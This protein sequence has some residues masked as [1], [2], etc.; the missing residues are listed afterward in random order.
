MKK[1]NLIKKMT[2]LI[3]LGNFLLATII[4]PHSAQAQNA[5]DL[6]MPGTMISPGIRYTPAIMAGMTIHPKNPFLFDFIIDTG[7]DN[8]QGEAFKAESQ[9]LI[10]YFLATLA[11]P[12]DEMWV[13]LSPHEKDRIVADSLGATA[14]G[15]DM[16]AQDYMLK[17][18]T[19]SL[20]YP[21]EKLGH[22]FWK[23]I[24]EKSQAKFGL[25]EIPINT[26]N[27][28]WIVPE[29]V[30]VYAN[31]V[32]VFV[33]KSHLKV[34]LEEDYLNL[35]SNQERTTHG[36]GKTTLTALESM[37]AEAKEVIREIIIPA[38]EKEVNEGEIF[39][40]LRQIYH[41]MILATWYKKNLQESILGKV[42]INSNKIKGIDLEDKDIKKKIYNQYLA[43]FEKGVYD[44]IRK[45]YDPL[46]QEIVP[47]KYFSGGIK[48]VKDIKEK[49]QIDPSS[50]AGD[51]RETR[52]KHGIPLQ[53]VRAKT[54]LIH[55][56]GD[57][58]NAEKS[59]DKDNTMSAKRIEV[60]TQKNRTAEFIAKNL[61]K[62][63]FNNFSVEV[64]RNDT[65]LELK[66]ISKTDD[67]KKLD[68]FIK[69][70]I[71]MIKW[72]GF[73]LRLS[74]D[75][76][77]TKIGPN[78]EG[79][80]T[81]NTKIINFSTKDA[82]FS[83]HLGIHS[84]KN[85]IEEE[86]IKT[87]DAI[88]METGENTYKEWTLNSLMAHPQSQEMTFAALKHQ[89][90]LFFV[91]IPPD[92]KSN[93]FVEKLVT[94]YL[95]FTPIYFAITNP[96]PLTIA[97]S[98]LPHV[99][100]M[101]ALAGYYR[102]HKWNTILSPILAISGFY[103]ETSLRSALTAKKIVEDI[104]PRMKTT[105][106]GK[107]LIF[108]EYGSAHSDIKFYI[109]N[110][111]VRE[112]VI[113]LHR[114]FNFGF[115]DSN[116]INKIGAIRLDQGEVDVSIHEVGDFDQAIMST[117]FKISK[118][119][120]SMKDRAQATAPGG[121]DLNSG[122]M[123]FKETGQKLK[124]SINKNTLETFENISAKSIEGIMSVIIEIYCRRQ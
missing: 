44:Y 71:Q 21:E 15:R 123:N 111:R 116:F 46:T 14:M 5:L 52:E 113:N 45:E 120:P 57:L 106:G 122:I 37:S 8:L 87:A 115:L 77:K 16:L 99:H 105:E 97:L 69:L 82:N 67:E 38:I 40:N 124:F 102:H 9:K 31:G 25:R 43:A 68:F 85:A 110:P 53:K 26:F 2:A 103:N 60:T 93:K 30:V 121:I 62:M 22:Q 17:Q 20:M 4:S 49:D 58:I 100:I 66:F 98:I 23:K 76:K 90:P 80:I 74:D 27:K 56:E 3:V 33:N 119:N 92:E 72:K 51:R 12:D 7:D 84:E 78:G 81:S 91:D 61:Q 73:S 35:K 86:T 107:P 39:A 36:L 112:F 75:I 29:E 19:A 10:N 11:I 24:Y 63:T 13:N 104:V 89:T 64:K 96:S 88:V 1:T 79:A 94:R 59:M 6:P 34:M 42:Y 55:N 50:L 47:K 28:V 117:P 118:E 54:P 83:L 109:E 41:S 114:R 65:Q 101:T 48:N 18:L 32:N 70:I 108:I 95:P